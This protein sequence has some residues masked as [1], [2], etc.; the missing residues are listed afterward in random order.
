MLRD[1]LDAL[2]EHFRTFSFNPLQ[3]FT[4]S[5]DPKN[6]CTAKKT[7]SIALWQSDRQLGVNHFWTASMAWGSRMKGRNLRGAGLPDLAS[8]ITCFVYSRCYPTSLFRQCCLLSRMT[9][10]SLRLGNVQQNCKLLLQLS[11]TVRDCVSTFDQDKL[12]R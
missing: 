7:M 9:E 4:M 2:L 10:T 8:G 11:I 3:C 1:M 12:Y 6:L 5:I